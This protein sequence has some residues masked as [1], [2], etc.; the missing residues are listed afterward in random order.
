ML[1][2]FQNVIIS[3]KAKTASLTANFP[4]GQVELF[5][6]FEINLWQTLGVLIIRGLRLSSYNY[7]TFTFITIAKSKITFVL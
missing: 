3:E 7:D 6:I 4:S 1:N 2:Y 5:K